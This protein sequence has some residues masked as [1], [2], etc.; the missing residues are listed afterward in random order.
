MK[1]L[2]ALTCSVAFWLSYTLESAGMKAMELSEKLL[3][4]AWE[5]QKRDSEKTSGGPCTEEE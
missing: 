5:M 3:Y 4:R 1:K 2:R